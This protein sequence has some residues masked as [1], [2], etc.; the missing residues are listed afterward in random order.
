MSPRCPIFS[1][2]WVSITC[3]AL[4]PDHVGQQRHLAGALDGR[5]GLALV[6]RAQARYPSRA[7]LAAVRDEPAQHVVVLVVDVGHVLL[8]EDARLALYRTAPAG[9]PSPFPAHSLP[10]EGSAALGR[11]FFRLRRQRLVGVA[12][13]ELHYRVAQHVVRDAQD[14]LELNEGALPGGELH[15]DVETVGAVVD[16]VGQLAP[17]PVVGLAGL[18][19]RALDDRAK[20]PDGVTDLLLVELGDH[21]EHGFVGSDVCLL[22][23]SVGF[24]GSSRQSRGLCGCRESLPARCRC[25][26]RDR[27]PAA[28]ATRRAA[29]PISWPC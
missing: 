12:R 9:R 16:L 23:S 13:R 2:S 22:R 8:A 11:D 3:T 1:T 29:G 20:A 17:S 15:D 28:R 6:L 18:A 19:T 4:P 21:Y 10:P 5:G 26:K 24:A 25:Y 7:D 14:A 27:P